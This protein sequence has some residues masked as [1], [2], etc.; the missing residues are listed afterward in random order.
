[1]ATGVSGAGADGVPNRKTVSK[2]MVVRMKI[3]IIIPTLNEAGRI[4]GL[5]ED[6][7]RQDATADILVVDGSSSDETLALALKAGARALRGPRGRGQQLALGAEVAEGDVLL[8]LHADTRLSPG[9]LQALRRALEDPAVVGGNF[10]ILFDG[11]RAFDR[12]LTGFYAWFRQFGFYYGDSAIFIRRSAFDAIGGIRPIA[13]MED[14]DLCRRLQRHGK[15][16]CVSE[17]PVTTS[18]RRFEGRWPP[19]IVAGWLLI[20]ALYFLGFSPNLLARLYR[21]TR[22]SP[23]QPRTSGS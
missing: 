21:S 1:M 22:Q 4:A 10:R 5:I 16:V 13:L 14:F 3:S 17:T 8:F 23:E 6:L 2:D 7:R 9:G 15:S 11:G 19:R 18:S 20:H 12:W